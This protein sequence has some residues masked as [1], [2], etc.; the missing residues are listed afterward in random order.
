MHDFYLEGSTI[1]MTLV[2]TT[3]ERTNS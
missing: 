1:L 3:F 2:K